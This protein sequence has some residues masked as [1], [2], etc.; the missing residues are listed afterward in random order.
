[1]TI[2]VKTEQMISLVLQINGFAKTDDLHGLPPDQRAAALRSYYED[3]EDDSELHWRGEQL[4][5]GGEA[6]P[7]SSFFAEPPSPDYP[8]AATQAAFVDAYGD[9]V[10]AQPAVVAGVATLER[11]PDSFADAAE[12]NGTTAAPDALVAEAPLSAE[13]I[14]AVSQ[15]ATPPID[16]R[17]EPDFLPDPV[18]GRAVF[19]PDDGP[20]NPLWW[21]LAILWAPI[22]GVIAFLVVKGANPHG[23][24]KLLKVSLIVWGV[25]VV[26]GLALV[27]MTVMGLG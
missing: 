25:C 12:F 15:P 7:D 9:L 6:P 8:A 21:V 10:A 19:M 17:L 11:E 20:V 14:T 1:M 22:G 18:A 13:A 27:A 23:A 5:T 26:L 2:D 4:W 3:H 16:S 24:A